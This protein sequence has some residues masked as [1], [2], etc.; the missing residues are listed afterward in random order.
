MAKVIVYVFQDWA[1][2][3]DVVSSALFYVGPLTLDVGCCVVR[4]LKQPYGEVHVERPPAN[5]HVS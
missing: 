4:R 3:G 2:Q 1:T 5:S